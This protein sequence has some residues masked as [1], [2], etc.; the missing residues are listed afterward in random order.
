MNEAPLTSPAARMAIDNVARSVAPL[1]R[2]AR[3]VLLCTHVNADGDTLGSMLAVGL[4]M[5]Q[6]SAAH[7]TMVSPQLSTRVYAYLPSVGEVL[8]ALP[9]GAVFDAAAV[10][11]CD[12]FSRVGDELMAAL[13]R[14]RV[15]IDVDHHPSPPFGTHHLHDITAS[16]TGELSA[17]LIAALGARIT[18]D[19]ATC[20]LTAVMTD[21]SRFLFPNTTPATLRFAADWHE[22]GGDYATIAEQLFARRSWA[23]TQL[24]ARILR[25]T[26]LYDD[27]RIAVATLRARDFTETGGEDLDSEGLVNYLGD[28]EGVEF[29]ALL[30][31]VTAGEVRVSFRS[32]CEVSVR[33]AAV[34]FGG[35]GH[36][37]AAG[38][39]L[40]GDLASATAAVRECLEAVLHAEVSA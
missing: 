27:G 40:A 2:D 7:V 12:Q 3:R 22:A 31:E 8:P 39:T 19:I 26:T 4:A 28:I 32:R 1:L 37:R 25:S 24:L 34:R 10:F 35:G 20:L 9:D 38:C 18:P 21:T 33:P 16:A 17:R 6:V 11:D 14:C 15:V 36:E 13:G 5:R 29:A 23:T 30:R